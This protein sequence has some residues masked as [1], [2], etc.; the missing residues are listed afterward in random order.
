MALVW[1]S[2]A[3][4]DFRAPVTERASVEGSGAVSAWASDLGS[5]WA[6]GAT[7]ATATA[8]GTSAVASEWASEW[9]SALESV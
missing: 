1:A 4:S 7:T 2:A 8:E 6:S 5:A 3:V 9:A